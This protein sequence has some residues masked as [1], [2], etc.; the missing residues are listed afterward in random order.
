MLIVGCPKATRPDHGDVASQTCMSCTELQ[1]SGDLI[2]LK[3][4]FMS[5]RWI[6]EDDHYIDALF[7]D[8]GD[9]KSCQFLP[10]LKKENTTRRITLKRDFLSRPGCQIGL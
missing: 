4:R 6:Y 7:V 8:M 5:H 2:L 10:L 1:R 3:W 9:L